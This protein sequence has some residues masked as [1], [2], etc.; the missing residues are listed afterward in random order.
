MLVLSQFSGPTIFKTIA[1]LLFVPGRWKRGCL[2]KIA[3]ATV[4]SVGE[5]YQDEEALHG[6][7]WLSEA[8]NKLDSASGSYTA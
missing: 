7:H 6:H 8:E 4:V 5:A 2:D 3:S 1:C